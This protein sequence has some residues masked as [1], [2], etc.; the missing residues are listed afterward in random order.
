MNLAAA[1]LTEWVNQKQ[2]IQ[3]TH[4]FFVIGATYERSK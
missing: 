1:Y 4:T 3:I 2:P